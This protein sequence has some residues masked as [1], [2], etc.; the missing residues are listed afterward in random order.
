[1]NPARRAEFSVR[2]I[3]APSEDQ[4][5]R[6]AR[7]MRTTLVEVLG[8]TEGTALYA[9]DWLRD[10]VLA[11]LDPARLDGALFLAETTDGAGCGHLLAR[12]ERDGDRPIGLVATV[13][14]EP[15]WRGRGVAH[16][17][18]DAGEA[19]L[20]ARGFAELAYDTADHHAR[21]IGLLRARGY[22]INFRAPERAMLRLTRRY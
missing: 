1:M 8:E 2:R 7:G 16:A 18:F 12:P 6:V 11:H 13:F 19:W 9:M 17:L 14:V 22:E 10:R 20:R 21:M 5:D 15:A 3:E 4:L